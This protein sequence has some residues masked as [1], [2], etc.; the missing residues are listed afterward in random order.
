VLVAARPLRARVT[1]ATAMRIRLMVT[2]SAF[3]FSTA[4][5]S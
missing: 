2:D 4:V 3:G 1:A 5:D